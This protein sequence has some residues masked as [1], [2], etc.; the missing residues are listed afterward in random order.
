[1][2]QYLLKYHLFNIYFI[3]PYKLFNNIIL[4]LP[5]YTIKRYT[6]IHISKRYF[7]FLTSFTF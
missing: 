4:S 6:Q 7:T 3:G 5:I 1:M 2:L